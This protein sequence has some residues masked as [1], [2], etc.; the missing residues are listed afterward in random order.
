MHRPIQGAPSDG[1]STGSLPPRL[2]DTEAAPGERRRFFDAV[3]AVLDRRAVGTFDAVR[4]SFSQAVQ[5]VEVNFVSEQEGFVLLQL[6]GSTVVRQS[7]G[8]ARLEVGDVTVIDCRQPYWV[9]SSGRNVQLLV[10]A[11]EAVLDD[12]APGWRRHAGVPLSR[13][14]AA[15][16]GGLVRSAFEQV[17]SP[18]RRQ[19]QA[20]S[21]ALLT[22]L[23]AG[24]AEGAE[25]EDAALSGHVPPVVRTIQNALLSRVG[26]GKIDPVELAKHYGLSERQLYRHF[27]EAGTSVHRWL[28]LVRLDRC[29][30]D[31][32]NPDLRG[33]SITEIAFRWGFNDAAHFSR[34]FRA[35]FDRTPR[36]HRAEALAAWDANGRA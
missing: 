28:K 26:D 5:M 10:R 1:Y 31:L 24:L 27:Q 11:P 2:K 33:Q 19:A 36:E 25:G 13:N 3:S 22:L 30:A 29:A 9:T 20:V 7:S 14:T 35:E 17:I 21:D 8:E 12:R 15:L 6:A 23:S 16:I 32:A 18:S 34:A 4:A